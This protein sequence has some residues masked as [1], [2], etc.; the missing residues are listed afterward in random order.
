MN[1][2]QKSN[3]GDSGDSRKK[4]NTETVE[5]MGEEQIKTERQF[6]EGP[7][8]RT[9]ELMMLFRVMWDFL[10]G[11]RKLHFMGPCVTVFGSA[12][13]KEDHPA[14]QQAV[15]MGRELTRLGFTVM[16]GG[17]PGIMEAANRGAYESGGHSVGCN[18]R[19]PFEQSENPYLHRS[20]TMKY[21]FVRKVLLVKYSYAFVVCPGGFGT[22]DEMF[23]SL[24]LIQTGK[25]HD[26]PVVVLG[27]EYW[28]GL[29][30]FMET[31]AEAG[32]ISPEDREL[33]L[34]TD[35]IEE[36]GAFIK[37]K[38]YGKFGLTSTTK[39]PAWWL[40]EKGLVT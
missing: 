36:A 24:T 9:G 32:T 35:S 19:L 1:A 6:L 12:R 30:E 14:Y 13:F 23:E 28:K 3:T 21:F 33:L 40:G 34:V 37:E 38:C 2:F 25:I 8:S 20:V 10:R 26:F 31:M 17:G 18:I 5:K 4:S 11:F 7:R 22:M 16:T 15:D 27:T 29:L 39:K